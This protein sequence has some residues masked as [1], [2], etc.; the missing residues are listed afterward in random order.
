MKL[1]DFVRELLYKAYRFQTYWNREHAKNP[2][3]FPMEFDQETW[4]KQWKIW[5]KLQG[6]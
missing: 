3:N 6:E 4:E 5:Q 1:Y 2:D